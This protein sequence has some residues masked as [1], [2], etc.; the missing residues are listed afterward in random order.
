MGQI[1]IRK[2]KIPVL[3]LTTTTVILARMLLSAFMN[4]QTRRLDPFCTVA[5]ILLEMNLFHLEPSRKM[6]KCQKTPFRG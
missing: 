4:N 3:I 5:W 6:I 1:K 2:W